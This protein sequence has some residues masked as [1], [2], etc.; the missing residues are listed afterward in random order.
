MHAGTL[1]HTVTLPPPDAP[2]T[3]T[4]HAVEQ[5]IAS[6]YGLQP[7]VRAAVIDGLRALADFLEANPSLPAPT[8]NRLLVPL[9]TREQIAGIARVGSWQKDYESDTW[10]S[11]K[12]SFG[13]QVTLEYFTERSNVCRKVKTGET[14]LVPARPAE[15]ER[16]EDVEKWVCD[17]AALLPDREQ[18]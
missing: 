3:E 9:S 14:R 16:I 7:D 12:R 13:P 1:P 11:L 10:F 2:L 6:V 18:A 15:P 17:D 5:G 4:D 8:L